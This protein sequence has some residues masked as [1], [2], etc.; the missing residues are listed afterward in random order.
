MMSSLIEEIK[1]MKFTY[2]EHPM[3]GHP[4]I[5]LGVI[6]GG[7]AGNIVPGKCSI[8]LDTR[9]VPGMTK[10]SIVAEFQKCID[11][12]K[13][14]KFEIKVLDTSEPHGIDPNNVVVDAIKKN[15]K[16]VLGFEPVPIGMGGG[17]FAKGLCLNGTIAV[18]WG[19]G[20]EATFHVANEY[21]EIEQLM[22]FSELTCLLAIDLIG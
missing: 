13:N 2:E 1:K 3:L 17:T 15:A 4:T 20:N 5:N 18:G 12:V 6:N 19:I 16:D 8:L 7:A 14:G 11:K 22:S 21:I 9:T 10:E